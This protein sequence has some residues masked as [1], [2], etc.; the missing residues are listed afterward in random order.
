MRLKKKKKK[1]LEA[2]VEGNKLKSLPL[3]FL[4]C[5]L[6]YILFKV[7]KTHVLKKSPS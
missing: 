3:R 2:N 1:T 4:K 7:S 6:F 5:R